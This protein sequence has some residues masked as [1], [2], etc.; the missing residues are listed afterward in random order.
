MKKAIVCLIFTL[1]FVLVLPGCENEEFATNAYKTLKSADITY[2]ATMEAVAKAQA[3][4]II[5]VTQREVI[6]AKARLYVDAFRAAATALY[7]WQLSKE[8]GDKMAVMQSV[9]ECVSNVKELVLSAA[10]YGVSAKSMGIKE[11]NQ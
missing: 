7:S 8:A 2:V 4:G 6:N 10:N 3:K 5:T 1:L 9:S 11:A